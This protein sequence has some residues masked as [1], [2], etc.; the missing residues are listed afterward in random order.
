M[1]FSGTLAGRW[2]CAT[3]ATALLF[4]GALVSTPL[5]AAEEED[6]APRK[7]IKMTVENFKWVPDEIAVAE[8]TH[9]VLQIR[10]YDAT[11]RFDLKKPYNLKVL[12]P[13]DET[14]EVEFVAKH[15]GKFKW[16][17]GRPCGNGCPKMTGKLTVYPRQSADE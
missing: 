7:V 13:Q 10:S 11:H 17:C 12:L 4:A 1:K 14:T 8:G 16:K 9:V 5:L 2:T 6:D 3:L 15:V